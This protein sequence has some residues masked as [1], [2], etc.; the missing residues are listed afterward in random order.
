MRRID[1]LLRCFCVQN[2][3]EIRSLN[4]ML[5]IYYISATLMLNAFFYT[6]DVIDE[7]YENGGELPLATQ[8]TRSIYS[9]LCCTVF[10]KIGK[11][12]YNYAPLF[13]LVII[14]IKDRAKLME[15]AIRVV[16]KAKTKIFRFTVI[17]MVII[18][19]CWYYIT[20][21]CI[22][23]QSSQSSWFKGG[24]I[25]F[26][27]TLAINVGISLV[28]VIL[29]KIALCSKSECLYNLYLFAKSLLA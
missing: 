17:N 22:V 13:D 14:E 26:C 20:I 12:F 19:F 2:K 29:R 23:Y 15:F 27:I 1:L 7:K 5:F 24:I 28:L 9:S 11:L 4:I 3:Y 16:N 8:A 25:S 18:I 6:D 21:F 10:I